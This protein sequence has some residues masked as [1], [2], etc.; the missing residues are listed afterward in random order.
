MSP[1]RRELFQSVLDDNFDIL[2]VLHQLSRY[3]DCDK[4]LKWLIINNIR[5]KNL[6]EWLKVHFENSTMSLVKFIVKKHNKD[7]EITPIVLGKNW[8]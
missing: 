1:Q 6:Q 4:I 3:T 8:N 2:P 5:G 7:R